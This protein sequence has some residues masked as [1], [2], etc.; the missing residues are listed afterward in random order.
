MD[1]ENSVMSNSKNLVLFLFLI[2]TNQSIVSSEFLHELYLELQ[3]IWE[4][5]FCIKSVHTKP[6]SVLAGLINLACFFS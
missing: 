6:S 3:G 2:F 1:E 5:I 4:T